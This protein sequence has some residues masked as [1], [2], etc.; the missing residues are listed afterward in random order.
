MTGKFSVFSVVD[1]IFG[2]KTSN[3]GKTG[4]NVAGDPF[5]AISLSLKKQL[6]YEGTPMESLSY[7]WAQL[8][9][10]RQVVLTQVP[11]HDAF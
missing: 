10:R 3:L 4:Q 6:P 1:Q 7:P 9:G 5:L 2:K 8:W 11:G